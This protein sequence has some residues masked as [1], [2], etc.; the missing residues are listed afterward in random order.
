MYHRRKLSD[1]IKEVGVKRYHASRI[2]LDIFC[3]SFLYSHITDEK[4]MEFNFC[5]IAMIVDYFKICIMYYV[6]Y[7]SVGLPS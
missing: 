6:K 5:F 3:I 1:Q 2:F 7:T 4:E